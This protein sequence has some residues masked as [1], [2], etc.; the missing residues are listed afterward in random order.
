MKK[1]SK[2]KI[3]FYNW[4][5]FD[6]INNPG[7]GVNVYQKNLID[8][9]IKDDKL[10]IYFLCSG[11]NYDLFKRKIYVKEIKNIY[12]EKC[13]SYT[14]V[15]SPCVAPAKA[16]YKDVET[17]LND[18]NLYEVFKQFINEKGPFD[19]IHFNNFE[20]LSYKC[21]NIKK[22]FPKS[23]VVY[24][25]HNYFPFCLQVNLFNNDSMNCLDYCDGRKCKECLNDNIPKKNFIQFYKIDKVLRLL[26]IEKYDDK[27]KKKLKEIRSKLKKNSNKKNIQNYN[28]E[29]YKQFRNKNIEALNKNFDIILAVSERVKKIAVKNNVDERL[30][31]TS[32]IG[33]KFGSENKPELH[34][35]IKQKKINITFLGYFDKPKGLEFLIDSLMCMDEKI[36]EQINFFC[37]AKQK[38]ENDRTILNKLY[39]L[40]NKLNSL[41][42]FNGYTHNEFKNIMNNTDLGIIPVIWED[43]LPQ[44]AIEFVAHGVPILCSDLG[45]ASELS[46][47]KDF[48][49]KSGDKK[50]FENKIKNIISN[51]NQKSKSYFKNA[52]L[53]NTMKKHVQEL[54]NYYG[55]ETDE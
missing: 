14:I 29:Y 35:K 23:K 22:D 51:Y 25:L 8:E 31:K 28:S 12:E 20:G 18:N 50:D 47:D 16:L 33:T 24:S 7:G 30:I 2:K 44:V 39:E 55:V 43:N 53:L 6:K 32:Y 34:K 38:S 54:Y 11:T 36:L 9:L 17:Y 48:V 42:Y 41:N 46:K 1:V 49:F 10:E 4:I 19:I 13:K 5:E 40:K 27:I 37:Y 21:I 15:N 26:K 3:L 52:I 45:G